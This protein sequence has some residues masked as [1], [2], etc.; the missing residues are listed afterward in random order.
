MLELTIGLGEGSFQVWIGLRR[1]GNNSF[2]VDGR[3]QTQFSPF[4]IKHDGFGN[5]L[6]KLVTTNLINGNGK[7]TFVIHI[8]MEIFSLVFYLY[9]VNLEI[10]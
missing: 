6:L 8:L 10:T 2:V 4:Q 5:K 3:K 7:K 9:L 1:I